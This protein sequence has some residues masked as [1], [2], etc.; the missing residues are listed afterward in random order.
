MPDHAP[1]PPKLPLAAKRLAVAKK[2][3]DCLRKSYRT[4]GW[5]STLLKEQRKNL[6]AAPE[7]KSNLSPEALERVKVRLA[8]FEE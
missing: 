7:P 8:D 6:D 3:C 5:I 4:L 2:R 1:I